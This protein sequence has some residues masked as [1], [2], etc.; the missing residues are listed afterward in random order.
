MFFSV[1]V[2]SSQSF[3]NLNCLTNH[4]FNKGEKQRI[5]T[6]C[7]FLVCKNEMHEKED[8][9]LHIQLCFNLALCCFYYENMLMYLLYFD[10]ILKHPLSQP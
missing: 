9:K 7:L 1:V 6:F 8:I 2:L 3:L 4:L 5:K 10:N